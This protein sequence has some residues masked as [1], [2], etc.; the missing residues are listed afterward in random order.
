MAKL[1]I[2]KRYNRSMAKDNL[3]KNKWRV[4]RKVGRTV[5]AQVGNNP[6][7]KDVLI[8]VFDTKELANQA[9]KDHNKS[10]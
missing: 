5:Y 8:G 2:A 7:N 1:V 9:V 3:V 4:G 10:L 6:T